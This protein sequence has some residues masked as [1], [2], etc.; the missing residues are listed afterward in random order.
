MKPIIEDGIIAGNLYDK[1]GTKNPL[2]RC[3]LK[4]FHRSLDTLIGET[5]AEEIHEVGCGEGH[6]CIPWARQNKKVRASDFSR[7]VIEKARDN[8]LRS[9]VDISFKATSIYDL[10]PEH[11]A[12]E[13]IVCCEVLEH[14][15]K[16]EQALDILTQLAAPY[17]IVTVPREPLWRILNVLRGK[18][19]AR[20]GNTPGHIQW[21]SKDQFLELLSARLE[22]IRV[23][24]P[25]PW[26]MA[27]CR[28][29]KG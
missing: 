24:C 26:T 6:L 2:A 12:A 13:L 21:W 11:D 17:L 8:A 14:L 22:I 5:G 1:C 4:G 25:I 23:K 18:Y 19:V 20:A 15:E 9:G 16:P 10:A 28:T 7:Q 27:L 29:S 3:L